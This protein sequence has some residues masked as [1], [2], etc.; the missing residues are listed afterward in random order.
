M[1]T[2]QFDVLASRLASEYNTESIL[3]TLPYTLCRW[4][5]GPGFEPSTFR[6]GQ[7]NICARDRDGHPVVLFQ[8]SWGIGWA[9]ENNPKFELRPV[10]PTADHAGSLSG[11]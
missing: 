5:V 11:G 4:I 1:G 8:N 7:G 3:E 2:L 10:S 9:Q 6:R